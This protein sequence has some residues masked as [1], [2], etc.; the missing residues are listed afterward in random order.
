MVSLFLYRNEQISNLFTV[1]YSHYT[2]LQTALL[3]SS[4]N[5]NFLLHKTIFFS[6]KVDI[7]MLLC[8]SAQVAFCLIAQ[9]KQPSII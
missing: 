3:H 9:K 6:T 5:C 4:S 1:D 8:I 7:T 2:K